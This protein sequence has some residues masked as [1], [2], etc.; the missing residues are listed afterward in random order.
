MPKKHPPQ[1]QRTY[2]VTFKPKTVPK[3]TSGENAGMFKP[4]PFSKGAG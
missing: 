1:K 2:E 3:E 4:G